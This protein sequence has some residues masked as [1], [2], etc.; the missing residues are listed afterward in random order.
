MRTTKSGLLVTGDR[1]FPGLASTGGARED[2]RVE[3]RRATVPILHF[4][5]PYP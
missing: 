4:A 1:A 3:K 2:F 5:A